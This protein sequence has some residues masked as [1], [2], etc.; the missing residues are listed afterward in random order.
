MKHLACASE[1]NTADGPKKAFAP[2]GAS[3]YKREKDIIHE[4]SVCV[5]YTG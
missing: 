5:N 4:T 1:A 2:S 3:L